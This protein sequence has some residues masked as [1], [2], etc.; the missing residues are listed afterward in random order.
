MHRRVGMLLATIGVTTVFL[1]GIL[2]VTAAGALT[3][4]L[5]DEQIIFLRDVEEQI[6]RLK[7]QYV[8]RDWILVKGSRRMQ[9]DRIVTRICED[10]GIYKTE[11]AN[12]R[13]E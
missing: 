6:T 13:R 3:G 12:P 1:Q 4:G 10:I 5:S 8:K 11:A 7:R 9:M 2:C